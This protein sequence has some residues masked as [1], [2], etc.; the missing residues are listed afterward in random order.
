[1]TLYEQVNDGTLPLPPEAAAPLARRP[2]PPLG[3]RPELPLVGRAEELAAL[4]DAHARAQPDGGLAVIEGE[5][6]IGKTRLARSSCASARSRGAVV[7]AARCH[8]DEAGLPY[9]P[10]VELL[11]EAV[12][13][14]ERRRLAAPRVPPQRLAD[15]SLL[16]PELSELTDEV[17]DPLPLDGPGAQVRLLEGVAAVIAAACEGT[18]AGRRRAR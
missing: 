12:R 15:A 10:I 5:A 13:H 14:V 9:G 3:C 6:G 16:L 11:R 17:P 18:A 4:I 2:R 1:M 8:D 7:L